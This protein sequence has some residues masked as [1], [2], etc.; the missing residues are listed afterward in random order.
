MAVAYDVHSKAVATLQHSPSVLVLALWLQSVL[1][2]VTYCLVV[3]LNGL[4]HRL[5]LEWLQI[6]I[7][8]K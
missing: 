8:C 6:C 1:A 2:S 4:V 7:R 5:V 3:N